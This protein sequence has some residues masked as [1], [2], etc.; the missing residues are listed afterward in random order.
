M[1]KLVELAQS[2]KHANKSLPGTSY[3]ISDNNSYLIS[4]I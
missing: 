4:K 2:T 3:T 1:N